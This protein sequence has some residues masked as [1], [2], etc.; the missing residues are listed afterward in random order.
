[1]SKKARQFLRPKS[2]Q[3]VDEVCPAE[4]AEAPEPKKKRGRPAGAKDAQPRK[5]KITIHEE[6]PPPPPEPEEP[7][8]PEAPP[9]EP[10]SPGRALREAGELIHR[11]QHV[12]KEARKTNLR[13]LYTKHLLSLP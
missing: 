5:K 4:P 11:S 13:E 1:L 2:L 12:K 6:A 3:S 9:P 8:Q 7:E 10:M